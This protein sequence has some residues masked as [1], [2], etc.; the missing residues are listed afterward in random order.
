MTKAAYRNRIWETRAGIVPKPRTLTGF[1][2]R[3][4]RPRGLSRR[5]GGPT[6]KRLHRSVDDL[7]QAMGMSGLSKRPGQ[8]VVRGD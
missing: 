4:E 2:D 8:P 6:S 3:A 5:W 1:L 7:A